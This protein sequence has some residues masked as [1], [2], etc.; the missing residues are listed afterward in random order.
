[1]QKR[2]VIGLLGLCATLSL[3]ADQK[4]PVFYFGGKRL[5]VGMSKSE[6]VASLSACCNLSPPADFENDKSVADTG[7][8]IGHFI[9]TKDESPQRILGSIFFGGGKIVRITRPVAENKFDPAGDDVVAFARALNRVLL[10]SE[11]KDLDTTV[12]VSVRHDRATNADTE[13]LSFSFSN[14]RGV[15]LQIV[16]LDTPLKETGKRDSIGLDEIL[17]TPRR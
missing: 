11:G 4:P 6:A 7:R 15:E 8:M 5:F 12:N 10:S 17:E 1:M 13:I 16:T 14:G 3:A 9:S 2:I